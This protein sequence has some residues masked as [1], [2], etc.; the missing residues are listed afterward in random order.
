[1]ILAVDSGGR[2]LRSFLF[3]RKGEIVFRA[4][5]PTPSVSSE[6]GAQ[7]HDPQMMFDAFVK[8]VRDVMQKANCSASDIAGI[9]ISAQ[10]AS[11]MLWERQRENR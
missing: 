10:R 2:S 11:F 5:V 8:A 6:P 7:E 9:G 4:S 3:N 1:M